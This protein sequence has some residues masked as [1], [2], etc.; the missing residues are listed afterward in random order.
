MR[1]LHLTGVRKKHVNKTEE[2]EVKETKSTYPSWNTVIKYLT[3]S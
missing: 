3:L 2:Y 1:N